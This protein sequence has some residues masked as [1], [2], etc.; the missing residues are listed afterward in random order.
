MSNTIVTFYSL[1][2]FWR[3]HKYS[4]KEYS[5]YK[6][7]CCAL[8]DQNASECHFDFFFKLENYCDSIVIQ[9]SVYLKKTE[10]GWQ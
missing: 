8:R 3:C 4:F 5:H 1:C 6:R 2:H 7:L 10:V 9:V